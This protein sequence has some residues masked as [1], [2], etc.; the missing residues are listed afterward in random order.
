MPN[1]KAIRQQKRPTLAGVERSAMK[2]ALRLQSV[3]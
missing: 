2:N 3:E 1:R